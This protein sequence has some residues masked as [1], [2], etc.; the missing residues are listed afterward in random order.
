MYFLLIL[1]IYRRVAVR[2]I[3]IHDLLTF[4]C[5]EYRNLSL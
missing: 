4:L 1:D 5:V 3:F 2:D